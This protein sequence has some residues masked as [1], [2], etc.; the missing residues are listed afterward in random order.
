MPKTVSPD[1]HYIHVFP[2][3]QS[4]NKKLKN[5][6]IKISKAVSPDAHYWQLALSVYWQGTLHK[7]TDAECCCHSLLSASSVLKI[8]SQSQI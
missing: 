4:F 7:H 8:N 6:N 5:F 2:I 1:A 3:T